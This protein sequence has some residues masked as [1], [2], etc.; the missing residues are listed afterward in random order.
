M[1]IL[2]LTEFYPRNEKLIF[3][4]GVE[5]RMYYITRHAEK[6]FEIKIITSSSKHVPATA[7]SIFSR[8]GYIFK[9]LIQSLK[10][11][12]DLIEASNVVTYLPAWL[13]AQIKRKPVVAWVPDILGKSWFDFG[14]LV[15]M[16]G[17]LA[18]KIYLKLPW[19]KIIALSYSTK[20][21]LVKAGINPKN[22]SV[23][24]AGIDPKEF[25]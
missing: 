4:G 14:V 12:F 11:D 9:S 19:T 6:D 21:K 24:H 3:T 25:K 13:A 8:L 15:G 17:L 10:T 18:E 1:R 7:W 23:V 20:D 16:A 5:A 22:I 2:F